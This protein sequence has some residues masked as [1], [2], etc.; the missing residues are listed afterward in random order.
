[1]TVDVTAPQW[2]GFFESPTFALNFG[3][4]SSIGTPQWTPRYQ[5]NQPGTTSPSAP[6]GEDCAAS[7]WFTTVLGWVA[8]TCMAVWG[9]SLMCDQARKSFNN[10]PHISTPIPSQQC[11]K[12]KGRTAG[13]DDVAR[14]TQSAP[15]VMSIDERLTE[16]ARPPRKRPALGGDV[17][18]D[19][20]DS[21]DTVVYS[22]SSPTCVMEIDDKKQ[23]RASPVG[24][25]DP[26]RGV[27]KADTQA[28]TPS[29]PVAVG[30]FGPPNHSRESHALLT[31]AANILRDV[32]VHLVRNGLF[33]P[34]DCYTPGAL[35]CPSMDPMG[36]LFSAQ[37]IARNVLT[38]ELLTE[39]KLNVQ[40][41]ELLATILLMVYKVRS[42]SQWRYVSSDG[43]I[44][45][46]V[47]SQFMQKH[48]LPLRNVDVVREHMMHIEMQLLTKVPLFR[49]IDETPHCA[50]EWYISE[51]YAD[52]LRIYRNTHRL[53]LER[54]DVQA[55]A[56][57]RDLEDSCHRETMLA[58]TG[59]YFF[60]HAACTSGTDMLEEMGQW[61]T[62]STMGKALGY[63]CVKAIWLLKAEAAS[64]RPV[65][66][67]VSR[68]AALFVSNAHRLSV[69]RVST[70]RVHA[71]FNGAH[72]CQQ[73]V[74]PHSLARLMTAFNPYL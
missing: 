37:T 52:I 8:S 23:S 44:S 66:D 49:L 70:L 40:M 26:T 59:A 1:M 21:D 57:L 62:A 71:Y 2:R 20:S 10:N 61:A 35:N 11:P 31:G 27:P 48:E 42:E 38:E 29:P 17:A 45:V 4:A 56:D 58:L 3:D 43:G 22:Q 68:A 73:I 6:T 5:Q 64:P 69:Q 24:Q 19:V 18:Y 12:D 33:L 30:C 51:H 34:G 72:P 54:G 14:Y 67:K 25:E 74:G 46:C 13:M 55:R 39:N 15:A 32:Y 60:Y 53:E 65:K 41:R 36:V 28:A 50:C 9:A 63:I 7:V 47:M 16:L